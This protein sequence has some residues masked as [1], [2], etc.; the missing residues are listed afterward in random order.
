MFRLSCTQ[1]GKTIILLVWRALLRPKHTH[2]STCVLVDK[3][4]LYIQSGVNIYVWI[5]SLSSTVGVF[6]HVCTS[7][8][9]V[10]R[11]II[12]SVSR[13]EEGS[14]GAKEKDEC[15]LKHSS[16]HIHRSPFQTG[17]E[18]FFH[19]FVNICLCLQGLFWCSPIQRFHSIWEN[20]YV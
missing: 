7:L 1:S 18:H 2:P 8:L 6:L 17:E 15:V 12:F 19:I 11:W 3:T 20:A 10:C 9:Y 16:L 5:L 14:E 4:S 13:L